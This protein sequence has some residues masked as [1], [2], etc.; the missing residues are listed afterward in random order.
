MFLIGQG[1]LARPDG[2]AILSLAA[3]AAASLGV[4]Q[5]GLEWLCRPAYGGRARGRSRPRLRA[6]R[7]RAR[8]RRHGETRRARRDLQPRRRRDRHRARRLRDLSGH[9][10]RSRRRARR[11]HP[12]G[13]GLHRKIRPLRQYRRAACSSPSGPIS[14]PATRARTGPSCAPFPMCWAIACRSI[15][16]KALRAQLIAAH[17]HFAATDAIVAGAPFDAAA[18]IAA[19]GACASAPFVSP[20]ADYSI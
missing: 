4:R 20:V 10:W 2:L 3:K 8:R 19:G 18:L 17:P 9:A 14:R 13:R 6:A 11:C 16:L 1:A 7:G 15:S 12:A 5:G